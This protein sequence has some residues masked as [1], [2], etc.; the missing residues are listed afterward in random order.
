MPS[1]QQIRPATRSAAARNLRADHA[2]L[3][4]RRTIALAP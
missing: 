2:I 4:V 1:S 3:V